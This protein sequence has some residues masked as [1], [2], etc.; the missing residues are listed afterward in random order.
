MSQ[1]SK[2]Y[3]SLRDLTKGFF[4]LF[5]FFLLFILLGS[6]VVLIV[7]IP[8][9]LTNKK[10]RRYIFVSLYFLVVL[11]NLS[12]LYDIPHFQIVN[13]I[14]K[15]IF[16]EME[17]RKTNERLEEYNRPPITR[18]KNSEIIRETYGTPKKWN[19]LGDSTT[20]FGLT[21]FVLNILNYKYRVFS[22]GNSVFII[23]D[24]ISFITIIYLI[25]SLDF[26][27]IDD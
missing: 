5:L 13:D 15:D 18:T 23:L 11:I 25:F 10:I 21:D 2:D 6:F 16:Y 22:V 3:K 12:L 8:L 7:L 26:L 1:L 9:F 24:L 17:F 14:N 19:K 20:S 27:G 4:I